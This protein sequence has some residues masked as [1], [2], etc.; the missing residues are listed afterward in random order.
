MAATAAGGV[1]LGAGTGSAR[2]PDIAVKP[3]DLA[4]MGPVEM[5]DAGFGVFK[6][7]MG[8]L[9]LIAAAFV[10]PIQMASAFLSRNAMSGLTLEE[11]FSQGYPGLTLPMGGGSLAAVGLGIATTALVLPVMTGA[12]CQAAAS[13]AL[14]TRPGVRV[15]LAAAWRRWPALVGAWFL[16]HLAEAAGFVLLFLPALAVMAAAMFTVPALVLEGSGPAAALGRSWRLARRRWWSALGVA[17]LTALVS[18]ALSFTLGVI[19]TLLAAVVGYE[20]GWALLAVGGSAV[21]LVVAPVVACIATVA[22]LEAR[23]RSEGMDL[24]MANAS[25]VARA[26]PSAPT[27]T[28]AYQADS[29]ATAAPAFVSPGPAPP[30]GAAP[31]AGQHPLPPVEPG[32]PWAPL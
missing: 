4:P 11:A 28:A 13:A 24:I 14:G 12:L 19:P 27:A 16:V 1:D 17:L 10:V 22:Y 31:P 2:G 3:L 9:V 8:P 26:R 32:E 30:A 18:S 5:V 21:S 20:R 6:A 15:P 7:A 29:A 25:L 23:V